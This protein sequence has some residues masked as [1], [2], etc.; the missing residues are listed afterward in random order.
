[1]AQS[2]AEVG[3]PNRYLRLPVFAPIDGHN[4]RMRYLIALIVGIVAL[5]VVNAFTG[6]FSLPR[7]WNSLS[8]GGIVGITMVIILLIWETVRPS[9]R[10]G[11]PGAPR[12]SDEERA[13]ARADRRARLAAEAGV[14]DDSSSE[15]AGAPSSSGASDTSAAGASDAAE[16]SSAAGASDAPPAGAEESNAESVTSGDDE[17]PSAGPDRS[18][19]ASDPSRTASETPG[20]AAPPVPE[21]RL[22]EVGDDAGPADLS[23]TEQAPDT[24]VKRAA[25]AKEAER[26]EADAE[27]VDDIEPDHAREAAEREREREDSAVTDDNR[28]DSAQG[29]SLESPPVGQ[30]GMSVDVLDD[31]RKASDTESSDDQADGDTRTAR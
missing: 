31:E 27:T 25:E 22:G 16:T 10:E 17:K 3:V 2:L 30:P 21:A 8:M 1:M 19:T 29:S 7:P 20:T 11:I 24:A 6:I 26:A 4:G 9:Q 5:F 14:R 13:Q 18:S 15:S 12:M 28:D 23:G